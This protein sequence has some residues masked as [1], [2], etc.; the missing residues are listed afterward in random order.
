MKIHFRFFLSHDSSEKYQ[1]L[2]KKVCIL[3]KF[4]A[5]I[6]LKGRALRD[7]IMLLMASLAKK[8]ETGIKMLCN[9]CLMGKYMKAKIM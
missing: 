9:V 8:C 6:S 5:K 2:M 1:N 4:H 3:R 7:I